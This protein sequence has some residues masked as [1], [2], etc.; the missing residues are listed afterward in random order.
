LVAADSSPASSAGEVDVVEGIPIPDIPRVARTKGFKVLRKQGPRLIFLAM[1][2]FRD[3][4]GRHPGASPGL[5]DGQDE[6]LRVSKVVANAREKRRVI[7][8]DGPHAS[9][10]P[11]IDRQPPGG[12]LL[13]E[14]PD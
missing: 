14:R 10:F 5:P 3:R 8:G 9:V 11:I 7:K 1:D 12:R 4:G 2:T 13:E 6:H